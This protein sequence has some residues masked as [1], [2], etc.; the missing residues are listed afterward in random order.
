MKR[1]WPF[2]ASKPWV[3]PAWKRSLS[4]PPRA[5]ARSRELEE[6]GMQNLRSEARHGFAATAVRAGICACLALAGAVFALAQTGA[7]ATSPA[8]T[9]PVLG[10]IKAIASESLTVTTDVGR[11][12]K[13]AI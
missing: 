7:P 2:A 5:P 8:K 6:N 13:V 9:P 4:R 3:S 12:A 11:E 10:T 1:E